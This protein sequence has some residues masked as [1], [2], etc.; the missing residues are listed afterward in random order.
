MRH[1]LSPWD[2]RNVATP[3]ETFE[4]DL[5]AMYRRHFEALRSEVVGLCYIADI[6]VKVDGEA[7]DYFRDCCDGLFDI[8]WS[9]RNGND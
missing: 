8:D 6:D 2:A 4:A 7:F 5:L 9:A 1:H 3:R